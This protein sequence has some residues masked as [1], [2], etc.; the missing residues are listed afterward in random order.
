MAAVRILVKPRTIVEELTGEARRRDVLLNYPGY[1]DA[2]RVSC[3]LF[4]ISCRNIGWSPYVFMQIS[5]HLPSASSTSSVP[6]WRFQSHTTAMYK[7]D[8]RTR[9]LEIF[10][11]DTLVTTWT[12]S[13]TTTDFEAIDLSGEAGS[14]VELRGVLADSEWLSITEVMHYY[15][16]P[17]L[18][19]AFINLSNCASKRR[20]RACQVV[21]DSLPYHLEGG[22]RG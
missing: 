22:R 8:T 15:I 11:D 16:R 21:R 20:H 5:K 18:K 1:P 3:W 13:G 2:M 4:F 7:G 12:S 10:I 19:V 17:L 9:T 14:G 6:R